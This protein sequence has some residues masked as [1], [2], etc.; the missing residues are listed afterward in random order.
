[1]RLPA[2]AHIR[3]NGRTRTQRMQGKK[4][5]LV[6]SIHKRRGSKRCVQQIAD[7]LRGVIGQVRLRNSAV[8]DIGQLGHKL[9][10]Y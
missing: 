9:F 6:L 8:G 3:V 5:T 10:S 2:H 1:M 4:L 7:A